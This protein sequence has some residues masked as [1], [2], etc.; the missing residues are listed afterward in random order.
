MFKEKIKQSLINLVTLCLMVFTTGMSVAFAEN[1]TPLLTVLNWSEY[2]D[3]EVVSAFEEK[4]NVKVHDVYYENDDERDKFLIQ[5]G[6]S[7]YDVGIVSGVML[8]TYKKKGWIDSINQ[9]NVPNL[10]NIDAAKKNSHEGAN[11]YS[12]PYAWG[13]LGIA[14]RAD[15]VKKPIETWMDLFEPEAE[16]H[17]KIV[18]IKGARE[19]LGTALN[20]KG[21]SVN[22][23]SKKELA[24]AEALLLTQKPHVF[25]YGHIELGAESVLATGKALATITYSSD[26]LVLNELNPNIK[27][28]VPKEGSTVWVDHWVVFAKSANKALAHQFLNFINEAKIAAQ[29]AEY[30]YIATPNLAAAEFLS[31]EFLEDSIIHP[32]AEQLKNLEAYRQLQGRALRTRSQIYNR[33]LN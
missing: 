18:M 14:Y 11:G 8:E 22:S 26:A 2:I 5:T 31:E 21:Y 16:L 33:V 27:Y 10:Q 7:G 30:L 15:L 13:T 6:G 4:Y 3:P 1:N 28:V 32:H 12:L 20:A 17:Q 23:M 19:L 9:Q 24:E 29:N 25:R